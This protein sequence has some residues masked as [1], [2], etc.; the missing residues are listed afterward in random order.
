LQ[1][2]VGDLEVYR[3]VFLVMV[4][5]K[6]TREPSKVSSPSGLDRRSAWIAR[7]LAGFA[8]RACRGGAFPNTEKPNVFDHISRPPSAMPASVPKRD[9]RA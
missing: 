7:R 9:Q 3:L 5:D 6:N 1:G 2:L 4:L 8:N